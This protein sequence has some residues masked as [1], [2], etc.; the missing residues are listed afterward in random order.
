MPMQSAGDLV[1]LARRVAP[2]I[3][4][5]IAEDPDNY[6]LDADDMI[7]NDVVA[8]DADAGFVIDTGDRDVWPDWA[9]LTAELNRATTASEAP[10][11][12]ALLASKVRTSVRGYIIAPEDVVARHVDALLAAATEGR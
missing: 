7:G 12:R 2:K 1:A 10:L 8:V 6:N 9:I 5:A 4:A 3:L 11:T